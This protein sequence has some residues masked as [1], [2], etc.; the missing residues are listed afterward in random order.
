MKTVLTKPWIPVLP[1]PEEKVYDFKSATKAIEHL[2]DFE[3]SVLFF[4]ITLRIALV[5]MDILDKNTLVVSNRYDANGG[6][7]F[8]DTFIK[9][10]GKYHGM[11]VSFT[12][13]IMRDDEFH[14]IFKGLLENTPEHKYETSVDFVLAV[15]TMYEVIFNGRKFRDSIKKLYPKKINKILKESIILGDDM[16]SSLRENH[17]SISRRNR[18]SAGG[19]NLEL[20]HSSDLYGLNLIALAT[21]KATIAIDIYE[22]MSTADRLRHR[23]KFR[24]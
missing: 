5:N 6:K 17:L 15:T 13:T 16:F 7:V 23:A 24:V 18:Q 19:V 22:Q 21:G 4:E 11:I 12:E 14:A 1:K 10:M 3:K 8:T 2:S 20:I 9:S